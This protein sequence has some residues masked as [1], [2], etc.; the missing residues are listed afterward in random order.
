MTFDGVS[1]FFGILKWLGW[2]VCALSLV[3][4]VILLND[5]APMMASIG[6]ASV[7][8][9]GIGLAAFGMIGQTLAAIATNIQVMREIAE[10]RTDAPKVEGRAEPRLRA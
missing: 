7:F 2:I 4:F 8:A 5:R 9:S 6:A 3:M 10:R 1:G